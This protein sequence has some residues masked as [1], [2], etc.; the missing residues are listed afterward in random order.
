[1]QSNNPGKSIICNIE[2]GGLAVEKNLVVTNYYDQFIVRKDTIMG[3]VLQ[4][5][6]SLSFSL[7]QI[8]KH[9]RRYRRLK[10]IMAQNKLT[11]FNREM[12]QVIST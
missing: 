7:R 12:H 3:L 9:S 5:K 4:T 8:T 10:G 1:M 6:H 2:L 11:R